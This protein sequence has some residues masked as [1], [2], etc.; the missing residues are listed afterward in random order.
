MSSAAK[1]ES[2]IAANRLC[3]Q[4]VND[5]GID[6]DG[7]DNDGIDNDDISGDGGKCHWSCKRI[8]N[9]SG[10]E[11]EWSAL[12]ADGRRIWGEEDLRLGGCQCS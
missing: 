12:W 4:T 9:N 11:V 8:G 1:K 7:I 6:D 3:C 10:R 5:N 2:R